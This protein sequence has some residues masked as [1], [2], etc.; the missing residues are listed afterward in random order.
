MPKEKSI[1]SE[2][3]LRKLYLEEDLKTSEIL[4]KLKIGHLTLDYYLDKYKIPRRL[5]RK[6]KRNPL[7]RGGITN[8]GEYLSSRDNDGKRVQYHRA[9]V[10]NLLGG[11]LEDSKHVHHINLIKKD[12]SP[13]NLLICQSN[14]DHRRLHGNL[15][16]I[17][18][19]AVRKNIVYFDFRKNNI[20]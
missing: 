11:K 4:R 20:S 13:D 5:A 3:L 19:Q 14:S 17:F 8:S 1:V 12:N 18:F 7:W 2:G 9:V 6:G 10:E 16:T 15:L